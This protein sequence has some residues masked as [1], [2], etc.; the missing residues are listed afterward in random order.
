[1]VGFREITG[2]R[3]NH[4]LGIRFRLGAE[5]LVAIGN[6]VR[7]GDRGQNTDDRDYDHQLDQGETFLV[8]LEHFSISSLLS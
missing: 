6:E 2:Q 7:D 1:V 4:A 8:L 5:G 3:R